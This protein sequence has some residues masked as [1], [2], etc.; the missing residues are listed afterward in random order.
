MA[1]LCCNDVHAR[2]SKENMDHVQEFIETEFNG[3]VCRE[4]DEEL[5]SMFD[6]KWTFPDK[7]MEEM[8]N[9]MPDKNDEDLQI[10]VLSVEMGCYY[11]AIHT[12]DKDGWVDR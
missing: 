1:N 10:E 9:L 2:G 6:S 3:D 12:L 4:E 7:A 8:W 5:T 11:H